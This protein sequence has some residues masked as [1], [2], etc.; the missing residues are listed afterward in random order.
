MTLLSGWQNC[1]PFIPA[2]RRQSQVDLCK[3]KASLLYRASFGTA[4]ATK[5]TLS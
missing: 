3:F 4:K 1:T 2:P 5:E